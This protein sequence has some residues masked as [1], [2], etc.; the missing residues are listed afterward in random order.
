MKKTVLIF[1][2][3][4]LADSSASAGWLERYCA[5]HPSTRICISD[6]V[7]E[8]APAPA[9]TPASSSAFLTEVQTIPYLSD[10]TATY[11]FQSTAAG[12]IVYGGA[13]GNADKTRAVAGDNVITWTLAEGT[14]SDCTL[15]I[16]NSNMLTI[17]TFK[18]TSKYPVVFVHG[19]KGRSS[20]WKSAKEYLIKQ[21]WDSSL[22]I[23]KSITE[24]NS[25]LCGPKSAAQAAEVSEWVDDAL[26]QFP[27]FDKVDLVGHSRGGSNIMRALW[28]GYI[29]KNSVR[30]VVTLA[31]ANR[32]CEKYYPAIPSDETPGSISVSVYYSDGSPDYDKGV[33]YANTHIQGAYHENLWPLSHKEMKE[34]P[35]ALKALENSLLGLSGSN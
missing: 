11:V 1:L 23:A 29:D 2:A 8:P 32:S 4:A 16:E 28:H 31:G 15:R 9:P 10:E 18:S 33:D 24:S 19:W 25:T 20:A 35:T 27:G 13:C 34:A 7:P 21:G 26:E 17:P 6:A 22:L 14:Y 3:I 12:S 5:K 30:Y